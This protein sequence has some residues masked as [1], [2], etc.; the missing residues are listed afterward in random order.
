VRAGNPNAT[1]EGH[2]MGE[3]GMGEGNK[4]GMGGN[5]MGEGKN[6]TE[7]E[8][9]QFRWA[10]HFPQRTTTVEYLR[11]LDS[12]GAILVVPHIEG[13]GRKSY[14][15]VSKLLVR[16]V[17]Y[18]PEKSK[19]IANL[20]LLPFYEQNPRTMTEVSLFLGL[21][22]PPGESYHVLYPQALEQRMAKME[23]E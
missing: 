2:G 8:K 22:M 21:K 4:G 18:D 17:Q 13:G 9:R 19:D 1:G 16:P 23:L 7:R 5:D 12:L 20:K 15:V 11:Q 14:K 10:M 3:S 6:L